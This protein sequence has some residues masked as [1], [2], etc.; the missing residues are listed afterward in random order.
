VDRRDECFRIG[1]KNLEMTKN[2]TDTSYWGSRLC[3]AFAV[4]R[5]NYAAEGAIGKI[6][7]EMSRNVLISSCNRDRSCENSILI[8]ERRNKMRQNTNEIN[9][10]IN[11]RIEIGDE[12]HCGKSVNVN[13]ENSSDFRVI[14]NFRCRENLKNPIEGKFNTDLGSKDRSVVAQEKNPR[15]FYAVAEILNKFILENCLKEKILFEGLRNILHCGAVVGI[16][17]DE[18]KELDKI[19]SKNELVTGNWV[20]RKL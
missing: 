16:R 14:D 20:K 12:F 19:Q 15:R 13:D 7:R 3:N 1:G 2:E 5:K 10:E 4:L 8:S 9:C 6:R 17:C 11:Q 18:S